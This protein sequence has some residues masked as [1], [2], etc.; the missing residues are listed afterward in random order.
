M[1]KIQ[2]G[3]SPLN[4]LRDAP[5]WGHPEGQNLTIFDTLEWAV[6]LLNKMQ[7]E[8]P[9]GENDTCIWYLKQVI[10]IQE[11]RVKLRKQQGVYGTNQPHK[12]IPKDFPLDDVG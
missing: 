2:E 6:A 12:W 3:L 11:H 7:Q 8:L 9:C 5:Y 4:P 10:E 1:D